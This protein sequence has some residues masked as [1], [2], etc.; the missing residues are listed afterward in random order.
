MM[1]RYTDAVYADSRLMRLS[2]KAYQELGLPSHTLRAD[3]SLEELTV[4]LEAIVTD[5]NNADWST[6]DAVFEEPVLVGSRSITL[7]LVYVTE[8]KSL[9]SSRESSNM[10]P[11]ES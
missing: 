8:M 3:N 6:E 11:L 2:L 7:P 1:F 4:F 10:P 5:C 9:S